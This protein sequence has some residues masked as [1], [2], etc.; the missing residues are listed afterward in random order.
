MK[1]L[2]LL[3]I[4]QWV[5]N[6]FVFLPMFFGGKIFSPECWLDSV[7]AFVV[8]SLAASSIYCLND[9][10]D[11][12]KDRLHPVKRN[13]PVASGAV[14]PRIALY[15]SGICGFFSLALSL[16]FLS[17]IICTIILLIYLA[18]NLGY[19]FGLKNIPILDVFII[20]IGFVLRL[21]E[22]GEACDIPLS[23]WIICMTFL[24]TLFLGFGKRRDDVIQAQKI[25]NK[26]LRKSSANYNLAFMNQTLGILA[27]ITIVCYLMFTISPSVT[28]RIG[29]DYLFFT[30]AFVIFGMLRY[31]QIAIVMEQSGDPSRT[32]I[33]DPYIIGSVICWIISYTILLY[34]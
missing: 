8:F 28:E 19:A 9:C 32:L 25:E 6:G 3:R 34:K 29:S 31:L 13:R 12:E 33:K 10:I 18:M 23:P 7:I 30:A 20:A 2:R 26:S 24:L 21:Y 27:A 15:L 22:G 17:N 1:Y 5:K 16:L 14:I 4:N 11:A